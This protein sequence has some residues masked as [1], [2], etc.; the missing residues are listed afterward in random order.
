MRTRRREITQNTFAYND[1]TSF[2]CTIRSLAAAIDEA[3]GNRDLFIS[4]ARLIPPAI[5]AVIDRCS[6]FD[7]HTSA[8]LHT[9]VRTDTHAHKRTVQYIQM[10]KHTRT[11][12]D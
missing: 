12:I 11:G 6:C 5:G 3:E 7:L 2:Q 8:D 1:G 4:I 9:H 10:Y